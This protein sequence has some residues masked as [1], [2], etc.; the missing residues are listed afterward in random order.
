M[1]LFLID[2]YVRP[3]YEDDFKVLGYNFI[4]LPLP[5]NVFADTNYVCDQLSQ[6]QETKV[7]IHFT[8]TGFNSPHFN[9]FYNWYQI[10]KLAI[11]LKGRQNVTLVLPITVPHCGG[12]QK[13][14]ISRLRLKLKMYCKRKR[15]RCLLVSE[16]YDVFKLG[17]DQRV[18]DISEGFKQ[19]R[20][21]SNWSPNSNVPLYSFK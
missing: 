18:L 17:L 21:E 10:I 9:P 5:F 3:Y 15:V 11:Q 4:I 16:Y 7:V 8:Y 12:R 1:T 20:T 2:P 14:L 19:I 6:S 13:M